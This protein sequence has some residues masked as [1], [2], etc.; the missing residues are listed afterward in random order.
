MPRRTTFL[1]LCALFLLGPSGCTDADRRAATP[2][3]PAAPADAATPG[4][5][6]QHLPALGS[7]PL[8]WQGEAQVAGFR[9]MHRLSPVREI[10]AG[11]EALALPQSAVDLGGVSFEAG[12]VRMTTDEYFREQRV[13]GLIV[14]KDG[15]VA[16]ERYGLGNTEDTRWVSFSV[17][18]SVVSMLIGAAIKDG[19]IASVDEKVTDYLPRLKGS[20]Y[21]QSTIKNLLQMA[22]GVSWNED[23]ADPRSD[24]ANAT[25]ETRGLYEYL[26]DK[27][28]DA[29]P[30]EVFNYNTAETN[31]A[32]TLLRSAIGNNL[33]T[34]L[35]DKIWRPFG[36]EE[37]AYWQLTEPAGGEFGGCCINA[38]LR[39]Y[40]RI[41]LFALSEGRL[42]DG[43]RV[44]PEGWMAESVAPSRSFDGY[45]Y[46]WWLTGGAAYQALGIFGQGIYVD[47]ER[48][49][50]IALHSAR[51]HADDD[52][53]FGMQQAMFAALSRA[54]GEA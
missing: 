18:K 25:Y 14:V 54:V 39:D 38:N 6:A 5:D 30:G 32:G 12:G 10:R 41:G 37:D 27:P 3:N 21:D 22:S 44:L 28:R 45:G 49:V 7:S 50:V 43:T 23:Y 1:I 20:S 4:E 46:F 2:G 48:H 8:F 40:A 9:N 11:D 19:Y 29:A 16:Y 51:E 42:A 17:A 13:G 52:W 26:R 36:M 31:L 53:E 35:S 24:V 15:H 34:Y 47:P 33:S